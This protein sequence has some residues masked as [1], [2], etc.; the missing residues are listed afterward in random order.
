MY[1][2]AKACFENKTLRLLKHSQEK[3]SDYKSQK[4]SVEEFQN[5]IQTDLLISELSNIKQE[6]SEKGNIMYNRIVKTQKRDRATSLIYGL[7]I[8]EEMEVENRKTRLG[9]KKHNMLDYCI[10]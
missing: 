4:I 3:D 7:T 8:V 1:T 2:Y 9:V 10:F 6:I 5:F